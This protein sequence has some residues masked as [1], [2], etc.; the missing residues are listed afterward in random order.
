[1]DPYWVLL[2]KRLGG[3]FGEFTLRRKLLR[4]I[5]IALPLTEI[6]YTIF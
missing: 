3:Y 5:V 1:M 2:S 4:G 6:Y